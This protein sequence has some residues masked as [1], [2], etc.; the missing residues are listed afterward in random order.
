MLP[1]FAT[2]LFALIGIGALVIDAGLALAEQARLETAAEM[3]VSELAYV[4]TLPNGAL[5]SDCVVGGVRQPRCIEQ[6][7]LAPILEPLGVQ[8]ASGAAS[9]TSWERVDR[10]LDGEVVDSRGARLGALDQAGAITPTDVRLARSSPLLFGW[11]AIAPRTRGG[12]RP[13]FQDVQS[14]RG[15]EGMSPDL[16]GQGLRANGFSL[17]AEASIDTAGGALAMQVGSRVP[18]SVGWTGGLV[19]IAWLLEDLRDPDGF[20]A[21]WLM[22]TEN[23][24]ARLTRDGDRLASAR[25]ET[26]ACL[27]DTSLRAA[28]VGQ[29]IGG[30]PVGA[31]PPGLTETAY[32]PVIADA[33]CGGTGSIIGF[34]ELGVFVAPP[35]GER[36][37]YVS[38]GSAAPARRNASAFPPIRPDQA[39]AASTVWR[40]H[41]L[42]LEEAFRLSSAAGGYD[43]AL[44]VPR[45]VSD[46]YAERQAHGTV[47]R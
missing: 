16:A 14:A 7:F 13:E 36:E 42:L 26:V 38:V 41:G 40:D 18:T 31:P 27:F 10:S 8:F 22:E 4:N 44:R 39:Q 5:P 9:T 17:Q 3:M 37:G 25:G 34:I 28:Y 1:L 43:L 29:A 15:S 6:N 12:A 33:D 19:G 20:E 21:R 45:V 35:T 46:P 24:D 2:L 32:V 47:S 11:A 23:P 30:G